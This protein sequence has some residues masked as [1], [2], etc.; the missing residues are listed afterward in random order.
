MRRVP[1]V[2]AALSLTV[3][4][5][6]VSDVDPDATVRISGHALD[7]RGR[8]LADT[9]VLL[10]KQADIGE[11]LVG[12]TLA[13]GTLSTIC[14]LPDP[15]AVC[16]AG[17]DGHDR[18]GRPLRVRAEGLRHP[19]HARDG[20]DAERRVLRPGGP[21][22]HVG[23]LHRQGHLGHGARRPAL[24]GRAPTCPTAAARSGSRGRRCPA[25][26]GDDAGYSAQLFDAD[27]GSVLW[28]QAASGDEATV[29]PR[30]LEDR[31][32]S[33]AVNAGT[34]LSGR[35]RHRRRTRQ[36]PVGP[37]AGRGHR[38]RAAVAR[39]AVRGGDRDQ[40]DPRRTRRTPAR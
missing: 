6:S 4:G 24:E 14:L 12:T 10:F 26:A 17:P 40:A 27:T 18:R 36:L 32:G 37:A 25:A 34:S 31:P 5:C 21:G 29:D 20:V 13:I 38:R 19:G 11:I 15:P 33:V 16:N 8:P 30:I 7:A 9:K 22:Q 3:I 35:Q 39:P 28:S 2:L 1:A 23:E